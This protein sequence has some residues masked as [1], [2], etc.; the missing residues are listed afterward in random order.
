MIDVDPPP[1]IL[2]IRLIRQSGLRCPLGL[3]SVLPLQPCVDVDPERL[4]GAAEEVRLIPEGVSPVRHA[5][6]VLT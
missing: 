1:K 5:A 6:G 2:A 4:H 3:K